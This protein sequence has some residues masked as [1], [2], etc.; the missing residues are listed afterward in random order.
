MPEISIIISCYNEELV[1]ESVIRNFLASDYPKDKME[2]IVGSDGSTDRTNDLLKKIDAETSILKIF[3]FDERRGKSAVLND[4]VPLAN[5]EILVL[6]DANSFYDPDAIRF[7]VGAFKNESVGAVSG[8]LQL[9]ERSEI[10]NVN[11][12][13]SYWDFESWLKKKEGEIGNLI[14]ANGG[15]YAIR[16]DLFTQ[17]PLQTPAPDDFFISVKILEQSKKVVFEK[18]AIAHEYIAKDLHA[19]FIRKVRIVSRSISALKLFKDMVLFKRGFIS[20]QLWSHKIL[21]W[22]M[23]IFLLGIL[24]TS[25]LLGAYH[26]FFSYFFWLQVLFYSLSTLNFFDW[27]KKFRI[28]LLSFGSYFLTMNAALIVAIFKVMFGRQSNI[29]QPVERKSRKSKRNV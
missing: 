26:T 14:G 18:N 12:E 8:K 4:L 24:V 7:L 13:K 9:H 28:S 21:R 10:S 6:G 25:Y 5:K 1:I 19:E 2:I 11:K 17:I 3:L 22:F 16:K 23:P 27:I 20:Y 15:I 29:W